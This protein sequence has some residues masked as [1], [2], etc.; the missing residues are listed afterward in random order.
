MANLD[1]FKKKYFRQQF[2]GE[3]FLSPCKT[4]FPPR[5]KRSSFFS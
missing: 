2:F 5:R 1:R 3:I 4:R